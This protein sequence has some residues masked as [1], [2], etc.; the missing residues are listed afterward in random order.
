MRLRSE[1]ELFESVTNLNVCRMRSVPA[2]NP[3]SYVGSLMWVRARPRS[4]YPQRHGCES[5]GDVSPNNSAASTPIFSCPTSA[6]Q[7]TFFFGLHYILGKKL[8]I[9]EV[10]AFFLV[11]TSLRF[12]VEGK[13]LGNRAGVSNLLNHSPISKNGKK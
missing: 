10:M 8:V 3:T 1:L 2:V 13:N 6:I 11:F 4:K 5:R 12:T 7:M 9:R